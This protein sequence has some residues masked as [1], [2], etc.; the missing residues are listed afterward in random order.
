MEKL[1]F[2]KKTAFFM[3]FSDFWPKNDIFGPKLAFFG[4]NRP[5]FC[6]KRPFF[7]RKSL[8]IVTVRTFY[9]SFRW[10]LSNKVRTVTFFNDFRPKNGHFW[11][12]IGLFWPKNANFGP[13]MSFFGQKSLK[14]T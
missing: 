12:K 13:K 14:I 2:E 3:I 4:Q 6:Q 1:K 8:K 10:N 5:I 7:G 9:E 11:Q